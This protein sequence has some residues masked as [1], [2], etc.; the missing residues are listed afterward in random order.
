[1]FCLTLQ[2]QPRPSLLGAIAVLVAIA[3]VVVLPAVA[4]SPSP[5]PSAVPQ[6]AALSRLLFLESQSGRFDRSILAPNFSSKLT[7]SV[8]RKLAKRLGALGAPVSFAFVGSQDIITTAG[9]VYE[10]RIRFSKSPPLNFLV[11]MGPDGK[12]LGLDFWPYRPQAH[13]SDKQLVSALRAT[14]QRSAGAIVR[15]TTFKQVSWVRGNG[16]IQGKKVP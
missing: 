9:T 7:P 4:Q 16:G 2:R 12:V 10:F 13:L 14:L 5:A 6:I 1:M 3:D 8:E 15:G 11:F